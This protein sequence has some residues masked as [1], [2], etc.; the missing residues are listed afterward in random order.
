M[1]LGGGGADFDGGAAFFA[2][3]GGA[4]VALPT[5]TD[6]PLVPFL[7]EVPLAPAVPGFQRFRWQ[8]APGLPAYFLA[9]FST[10]SSAA[11]Q[12]AG[13]VGAADHG[14]DEGED[15]DGEAALPKGSRM[16]GWVLEA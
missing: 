8:A 12:L 16:R 7:P 6:L 3:A 2:F 10:S 9:I 14:H 4:L 5:T 15:G 11:G 13:S 1:L